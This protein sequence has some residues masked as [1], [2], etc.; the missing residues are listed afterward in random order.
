MHLQIQITENGN[1]VRRNRLS[2]ANPKNDMAIGTPGS[3]DRQPVDDGLAGESHET[4]GTGD[5]PG[6]ISVSTSE[7][8]GSAS[9]NSQRRS[10]NVGGSRSNGGGESGTSGS[11]EDFLADSKTDELSDVR[12]LVES[13]I[14]CRAAVKQD[15]KDLSMLWLVARN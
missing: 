15:G 12:P 14:N 13:L 9:E 2:D 11:V 6:R 1:A 7:G 3:S 5:V 4:P 8:T 10:I